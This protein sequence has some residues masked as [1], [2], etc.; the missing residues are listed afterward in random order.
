MKKN[1]LVI[2]TVIFFLI[3]SGAFSLTEEKKIVSTP[4]ANIQQGCSEDDQET[5]SCSSESSPLFDTSENKVSTPDPK[6][7]DSLIF[8]GPPSRTK[9]K[10]E[11]DFSERR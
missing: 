2:A 6:S 10:A 11:K 7:G 5:P 1:I 4:P 9:V 8:Q 3:G